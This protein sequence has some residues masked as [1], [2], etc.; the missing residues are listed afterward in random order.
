MDIDKLVSD[1]RTKIR[2]MPDDIEPITLQLCALMNDQAVEAIV[3]VN[4]VVQTC[5][6]EWALALYYEAD[7]AMRERRPEAFGIK[8]TT[9][10]RT[11]GG[12]FLYLAWH[13]AES[14]P[15]MRRARYAL[16]KAQ[17]QKSLP[18]KVAVKL[19]A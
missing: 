3:L 12:L 14:K 18:K 13:R 8:E 10:L 1:W 17:R 6:E 4:A 7:T 15:A 16:R 19:G 2:Y 9:R 5:G 11:L